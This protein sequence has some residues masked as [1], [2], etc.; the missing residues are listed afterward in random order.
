MRPPKR[1][2]NTANAEARPST[3]TT[4]A[5]KARAAQPP[6]QDS[7]NTDSE[8]ELSEDASSEDEPGLD[9]MPRTVA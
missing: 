9:D 3:T 7:F 1:P 2:R 6:V 8:V 5:R 4:R